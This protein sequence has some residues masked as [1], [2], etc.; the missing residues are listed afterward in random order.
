MDRSVGVALVAKSYKSNLCLNAPV[1]KHKFHFKCSIE[2][3]LS[4]K[5]KPEFVEYRLVIK[6]G[7]FG[8]ESNL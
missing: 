8:E 1:L 4:L 2:N 7:T 3:M 6:A 5:T